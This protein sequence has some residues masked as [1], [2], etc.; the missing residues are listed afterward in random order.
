MKTLATKI[1]QG[2]DTR[3]DDNPTADSENSCYER[4]EACK[5]RKIKIHARA[6]GT[7]CSRMK[8]KIANS[9]KSYKIGLTDGEICSII[10]KLT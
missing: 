7:C 8:Y 9:I 4:R 3:H 5:P 1:V 10:M 2:N 6:T